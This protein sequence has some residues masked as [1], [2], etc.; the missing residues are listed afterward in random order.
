MST[1]SAALDDELALV[2]IEERGVLLRLAVIQSRVMEI[3][4]ARSSR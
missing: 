4:S 2:V 3:H 1:S